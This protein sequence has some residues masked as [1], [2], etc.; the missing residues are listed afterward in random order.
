MKTDMF[1]RLFKQ[2]LLGGERVESRWTVVWWG[3]EGSQVKTRRRKYKKL[4]VNHQTIIL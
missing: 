4:D 2:Y 3:E 1:T